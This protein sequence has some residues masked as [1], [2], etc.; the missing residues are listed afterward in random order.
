MIRAVNEGLEDEHV[1]KLCNFL[2][3]RDLI[4]SLNLRRNKIGNIGA[5]A[6]AD[7]VRKAD[8]TL[9]S[10]ELERNDIYDEG[11]E[12]LLK[13]MQSNM[14]MECCKMTYGNPLRQKIC[15]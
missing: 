10:L 4:Q 5:I 13:A 11:G 6:I 12:A 3:G 1:E 15:R 8:K 2:R 14:R 9:T 7:Y